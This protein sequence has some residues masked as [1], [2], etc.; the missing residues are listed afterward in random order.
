MSQKID[1]LLRKR[2][3]LVV[4][5]FLGAGILGLIF[6]AIWTLWSM[7][8]F[9]K[10]YELNCIF[11]TQSAQSLSQDSTESP[12]MGINQGTSVLINGVKVGKVDSVVLAPSGDVRIKLEIEKKYQDH[13]TSN[14]IATPI[15]ER[16]VISDRVINISHGNGGKI[17]VDGDELRAEPSRDIE[18]FITQARLLLKEVENLVYLGDTLI[19]MMRRPNSTIGALIASDEVYKK[20]NQSLDQLN[21]LGQGGIVTV[22]QINQNTPALLKN[23]RAIADNLQDLTNQGKKTLG[24]TDQLLE[25]GGTLLGSGDSL[26]KGAQ[27]LLKSLDSILQQ[28]GNTLKKVDTTLLKSGHVLDSVSIPWLLFRKQN[29]K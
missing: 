12:V 19:R 18:G 25:K 15:R 22:T 28:S 8:T 20:I 9:T 16:N 10:T 27:P 11:K 13:I 2:Q 14:S 23:A 5:A 26:A 6:T 21:Q 4:G 7:G 1:E 29:P 17:L 3:E 24:K